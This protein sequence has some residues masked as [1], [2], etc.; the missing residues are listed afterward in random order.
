MIKLSKVKDIVHCML[1]VVESMM[2]SL[3]IRRNLRR[4]GWSTW[5]PTWDGKNLKSN[6]PNLKLNKMANIGVSK[7]C[8]KITHKN[9]QDCWIL[10]ILFTALS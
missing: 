9:W 8:K 5:M 1:R 7:M 6:Q 2:V 10:T 4:S 3:L